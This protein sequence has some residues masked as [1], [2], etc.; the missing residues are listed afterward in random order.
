MYGCVCTHACARH[1]SIYLC[2]CMYICVCTHTCMPVCT[3]VYV[4]LC[5]HIGMHACIHEYAHMWKSRVSNSV[6]CCQKTRTFYLGFGIKPMSSCLQYKHSPK[7]A[8]SR[9]A[10][11]IFHNSLRYQEF[12]NYLLSI[13]EQGPNSSLKTE[14]SSSGFWKILGPSWLS[15]KQIDLP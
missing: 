6:A 15:M 1:T 7:W 14:D 4:H 9:A 11:G 3:C 12:K 10:K 5:V 13:T 2:V 8:I